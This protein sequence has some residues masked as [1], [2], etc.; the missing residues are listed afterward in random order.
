MH[1]ITF[2]C[3]PSHSHHDSIPYLG[4]LPSFPS[5]LTSPSCPKLSSSINRHPES[6]V[7][8]SPSPQKLPTTLP[9]FPYSTGVI[10]FPYFFHSRFRL[11][12]SPASHQLT[13]IGSSL[14]LR[15]ATTLQDA[16]FPYQQLLP[17]SGPLP[18]SI[19]IKTEAS[20]PNSRSCAVPVNQFPFYHSSTYSCSLFSIETSHNHYASS[21][22]VLAIFSALVSLPLLSPVPLHPT[23]VSPTL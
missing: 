15:A 2:L 9:L 11:P 23:K 3:V 18:T 13:L 16:D 14:P 10:P 5:P 20:Q 8:I 22:T 1:P 12:C 21:L 7:F 19:L 6:P 17:I 4:V